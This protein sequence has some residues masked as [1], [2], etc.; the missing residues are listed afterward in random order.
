MYCVPRN[1]V[2]S[3]LETAACRL[4]DAV[5]NAASGPASE[6][7]R[8]CVAKVNVPHAETWRWISHADRLVLPSRDE[9]PGILLLEAA[10]AR[11]PVVATHLVGGVPEFVSDKIHGLLCQPDRPDEIAQAV[12]TTLINRAITQERV[13]SFHEHARAFA[14]QR[15]FVRYRSNAGLP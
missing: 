13:R 12:L 14:W 8:Y 3:L 5:E 15:A 6:S 4:V 2:V 9:P 11:T 1:Q 7:W 10:E